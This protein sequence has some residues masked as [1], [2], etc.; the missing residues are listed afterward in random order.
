[1]DQ[2]TRIHQPYYRNGPAHRD[3]ADVSFTDIVKIFGFRTVTIGKWVTKQ[4]Q[5]LAANLFFD[6]LCDLMDILAVGESII[7]LRGSLSLAFGS[8]GQRGASAHYA[9]QG[10]VL[11]LAKNAGGG[12]LAHEWFHAFDHHICSKMFV[13]CDP[14]DFASSSWLLDQKQQTHVLN[15]KL[16]LCFESIFLQPD[17]KHPSEYVKRSAKNDALQQH[18]YYARPQELSARAFEACVQDQDRKNSFL[19]QGTKKSPEAQLGIYPQ[20]QQRLT[21]SKNLLDYFRHLGQSMAKS[22]KL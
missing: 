10:K 11:A 13:H 17:K 3:G 1:M 8:G 12:S 20:A 2:L 21:I 19:V 18:F 7:S 22:K 16:G 5:Q 4:E 14:S 9:P 6:A 15:Q